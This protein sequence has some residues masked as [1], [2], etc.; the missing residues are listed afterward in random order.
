MQ[1]FFDTYFR[2][3]A[4]IRTMR[5]SGSFL[6]FSNYVNYDNVIKITKTLEHDNQE[7]IKVVELSPSTAQNRTLLAIEL[8]SDRQSKKPGI[9]VIGGNKIL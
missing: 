5:S 3:G 4:K 7:I 2:S 9:L 8:R 1:I 6:T